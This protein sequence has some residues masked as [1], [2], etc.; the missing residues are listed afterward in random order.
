MVRARFSYQSQKLQSSEDSGVAELHSE[1]KRSPNHLFGAL[2]ALNSC[3]CTILPIED[4][5]VAARL[6]TVVS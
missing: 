5:D 6:S 2:A 4:A 1:L 3:R